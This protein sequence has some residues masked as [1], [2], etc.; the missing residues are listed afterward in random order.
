MTYRGEENASNYHASENQE[1][2]NG[3]KQSFTKTVTPVNVRFLM[4]HDNH[5][6]E[7]LMINGKPIGM[8]SVVGQVR[9]VSQ[10]NMNMSYLVEDDTGR[11]EA[12]HYVEESDFVQI[13]V[14]TFVKIIGLIKYGG[15]RL[16]LTV[17]KISS[18]R[19][20]HE[21]NAH[22]LEI[23]VLPLRI[24][25][26]Q[27]MA[28]MLAQAQATFNG[29]NF[30][31]N[32][33]LSSMAMS[34]PSQRPWNGDQM[35]CSRAGDDMF[36]SNRNIHGMNGRPSGFNN[37]ARNEMLN[38][39]NYPQGL[40]ASPQTGNMTF[41]SNHYVNANNNSVNRFPVGNQMMMM[42]SQIQ[43]MGPEARKILASIKSCPME[44]GISANDLVRNFRSYLSEQ[45]I[46]EILIYLISE[47]HIYNTIDEKH[48]KS[49]D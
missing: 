12:I 7:P 16:M 43:Q 20:M 15:D 41:N 42:S 17:Y 3:S 5:S 21:V 22:K 32:F 4:Q 6:N 11:I 8:V 37:A 35:N 18:V 10:G 25:K 14:N 9:N 47:G 48:F 34:T 33:G 38:R 44:V 49:T 40:N 26:V 31:N 29:L 46:R 28:A 2:A 36:S 45:K 23:A 13:H 30:G 39:S 24:A 19:N 27:S 1:Q